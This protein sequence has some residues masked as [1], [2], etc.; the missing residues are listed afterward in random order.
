M[1]ALGSSAAAPWT[2]GM[3]GATHLPHAR[4]AAHGAG[5]R[6]MAPAEEIHPPAP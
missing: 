2:A 3:R 6:L 5:S 4:L 1:M